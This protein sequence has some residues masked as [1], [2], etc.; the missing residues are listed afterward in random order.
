MHT[1]VKTALVAGL[2]TATAGM[3]ANAASVGIGFNLG[4]VSV[5]FSDGYWDND[6]HFHRWAHR[7]DME[8]FRAAHADMYHTWRHDDAR[9]R[10]DR[11]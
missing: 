7:G 9:H 5:G 3:T 4:D 11:Y 2:L 8:K 1:I 10:N 6:H